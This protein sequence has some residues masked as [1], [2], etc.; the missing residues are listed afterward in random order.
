MEAKKIVH[1]TAV[2]VQTAVGGTQKSTHLRMMQREGCHILVGT[3]GRIQDLLS[4]ESSGVSLANIEAFVLDEA[5]RLLDIGF[6]PAIQEIQSYLPPREERERQTLMFSATVPKEVVTLVRQTLRPDFKFVRTVDPDEAPTHAR[7][8]QHVSFL[9]GLENQLPAILELGQNCILAH[10]TDP[11]NNLPFKAIVYFASTA[12]VKLA[13]YVFEELRSPATS[14]GSRML[15][16]HPLEP[17]RIHDRR[18]GQRDEAGPQRHQVPGEVS[19]VHRGDI[20]RRQRRE[21]AC[22]VPVVEV[23]LVALHGVHRIECVRRALEELAGRDVAEVAGAE[24]GE[25]SEPHVRRR[26]AMREAHG[27]M[28]LVIV[29]RQPVVVGTDEGFEESPRASR[30]HAQEESL[31]SCEPRDAA[32]QRAAHPPREAG[33]EEPKQEDRRGGRESGRKEHAQRDGRGDADRRRGPH[34]R[35]RRSFR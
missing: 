28:F 5:D 34:R 13:H 14:G 11:E 25:Q 2:K 23:P 33:C 8:P 12:E 1:N 27:G 35:H 18:V 26:G 10:K 22:V 30:E 21:R 32:A 16:R 31:L 15:A 29:R 17:T 19:A 3:P 20:K 4:D 6:M 24:V 9:H 7:V